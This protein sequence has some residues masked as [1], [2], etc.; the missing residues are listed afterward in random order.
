MLTLSPLT[1]L[2]ISNLIR[3]LIL[4]IGLSPLLAPQLLGSF[5]F[6]TQLQNYLMLVP[7][8]S[9]PF[10][11]STWTRLG[12]FCPTWSGFDHATLVLS[13]MKDVGLHLSDMWGPHINHS[14]PP[15]DHASE[16]RPHAASGP[17]DTSIVP[18][19]SAAPVPPPWAKSWHHLL[20]A[21]CLSCALL[22]KS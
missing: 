16:Q 17:S 10:T 9:K 22:D 18:H 6:D 14:S 4:N 15:F 11:F 13:A 12:L 19:V 21:S 7:Q 5:H 20:P 1:L 2:T 3:E 8:L